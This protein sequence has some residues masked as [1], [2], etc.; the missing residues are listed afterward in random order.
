MLGPYWLTLWFIDPLVSHKLALL[1]DA[2]VRP[3]QFRELVTEIGTIVGVEATADLELTETKPVCI[4][5]SPSAQRLCENRV[6]HT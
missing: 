3:K 1:R 2:R 4:R 5:Q 6:P